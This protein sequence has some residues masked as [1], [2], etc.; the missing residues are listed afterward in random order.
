VDRFHLSLKFFLF[1]SHCFAFFL[2]KFA[3]LFIKVSQSLSLLSLTFKIFVDF[4]NLDF[5]ILDSGL[6]IGPFALLA[7]KL[8]LHV[9]EP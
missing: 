4:T 1:F 2:K 9:F 5:H 7:L 6:I 8:F 3:Q